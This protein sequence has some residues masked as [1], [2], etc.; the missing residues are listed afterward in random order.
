MLEKGK[1]GKCK[2]LS[3]SEKGHIVLAGSQHLQNSRCS[4]YACWTVRVPTDPCGEHLWSGPKAELLWHKFLKNVILAMI[5]SCQN[6]VFC[7]LLRIGLRSC[8]P[9]TVPMVMPVW[10]SEHQSYGPIRIGLCS[11]GRRWSS[12]MIHISLP[13]CRRLGE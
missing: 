8:R 10:N 4:W 9:I 13:S 5:D 12:L 2:D 3:N 11:Y 6:T 1:M 7:S